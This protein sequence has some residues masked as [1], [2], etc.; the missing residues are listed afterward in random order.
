MIRSLLFGDCF[1]WDAIQSNLTKLTKLIKEDVE[2]DVAK[3]E[4]NENRD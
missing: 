1:N 4:K 2:P 3:E